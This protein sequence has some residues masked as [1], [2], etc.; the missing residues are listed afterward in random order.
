MCYMNGRVD[1]ESIRPFCMG[2]PGVAFISQRYR[3]T[4]P[5]ARET[6]DLRSEFQAFYSLPPASPVPYPCLVRW[7]SLSLL[8]PDACRVNGEVRYGDRKQE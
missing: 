3:H 2:A 6:L 5:G 7:T 8:I 4:L 1:F